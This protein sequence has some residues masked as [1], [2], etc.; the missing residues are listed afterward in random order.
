MP[1]IFLPIFLAFLLLIPVT[2]ALDA[3]VV[4]SVTHSEGVWAAMPMEFRWSAI[5]GANK[6]CWILVS[7][8]DKE[9]PVEDN[10][11][12]SSTSVYPPRKMNS[13]EYY[14]VIKSVNPAEESDSTSYPIKL[15]V[16]NPSKPILSAE[17]VSDGSID[18][19][20][21]PAEDDSSGV[22]EYELYRKLM[23]GFDIRTTPI[24][25]I[26]PLGT[27]SINDFNE[28]D[29]STTYHYK[30][31]AID[32]AGNS[33]IVSNE[34]FA[35]TA[36]KCD[37]D[38]SFS[39]E[40]SDA[41]N[42]LA[43]SITSSDSIYRGGLKAILP[44]GSTK[45]FFESA[46]AFTEWNDSIDLSSIEEGYIDF[47][48]AAEEFFGDNCGFEKRFIYDI[49][50]PSIHF[51]FPKY[52][53]R[54]SE[55]V[56]FQV[57][58]ED[59]GSFKSGLE[60]VTFFIQEGSSWTELG[61]VDS[62]E[63]NIYAFNW[64]SFSA[65]NGSNKIKAV[66][67]DLAGNQVEATQSITVLNA[68][69]SVVDTNA[70]IEQAIIAMNA[71]FETKAG[72]EAKAIFS[73]TANSLIEEANAKFD[74]AILLSEL[75]GLESQT[76]AKVLLSEAILLLKDSQR[77]VTTSVYNTADFI[78]NKEQAGILLNAA[79]I[80]GA[81]EQQALQFIEKTDPKR[82]LQ[83]LRVI[84]DNTEYFRA[85]ITISY[86]LD[87][88][89][90]SDN[91]SEDIVM[92]VVEVVPKEFAEYAAE[93][94]SN[95]SFEVLYDD[96]K[97]SFELTKEE[98]RKKQFSYALKDNLSQSQADALI[99]EN[100]INKFVAPPVFL[101]VGTVVSL[102]FPVSSD[103]LLFSGIAIGVIIV[104]LVV[105]VLLK[106]RKSKRKESGFGGKTK[107][108]REKPDSG[109]GRKNQKNEK[110]E[111]KSK[112]KSKSKINFPSLRKKEESP[113]SVFGKK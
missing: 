30:I 59:Q 94:D 103:V 81:I 47:T 18:L 92:Q 64:D 34:A 2:V 8:P 10:Y 80:S 40:L 43:L 19:S 87:I 22:K 82:Q 48:L 58:A 73:E 77:T 54:V 49:T 99:E 65:E 42:S 78:F 23:G 70:A 61:T 20:W 112:K 90:L 27:T 5:N 6:Y 101:P 51:V 96:P 1:K 107:Q 33:G 76:N 102:G 71:A 60:P 62:G 41:G 45:T 108:G 57:E 105:L 15:D 83:I 4:T 12:T 74:E 26:L 79:G 84:D 66:A 72:L 11:C 89:I 7:V 44:D 67:I 100:V 25:L 21:E 50:N 91:N 106:K 46:S 29:Q 52:N 35:Q 63:N 13:G 95:I 53:D 69:E 93:L 36:A 86:S 104:V 113:L 109:L 31:R 56:P 55:T 97:L 17:S 88:N 28:M 110:P 39:T 68:F 37:L 14:F 85:L 32:N 24:Y 111:F 3:P 75:P 38:I 16:D 98:Y 9:I